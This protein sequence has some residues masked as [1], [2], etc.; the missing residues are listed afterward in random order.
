MTELESGKVANEKVTT[1]Q[2]KDKDG[3]EITEQ[4]TKNK[5]TG[6]ITRKVDG[7][8]VKEEPIE[9]KPTIIQYQMGN[10]EFI[11]VKQQEMMINQLKEM[12]FYLRKLAE[13]EG[14]L[15]DNKLKEELK[16]DG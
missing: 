4:V 14:L 15:D 10:G 3:K 7:Q 16:K 11:L 12:N 5:D 1:Y 9:K 8:E 2:G 6:E 13:K